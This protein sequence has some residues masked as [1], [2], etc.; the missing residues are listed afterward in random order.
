MYQFISAKKKTKLL[1]SFVLILSISVYI[2]TSC[3]NPLKATLNQVVEDYSTPRTVVYPL[4]G[5]GMDKSAS[6]IITFSML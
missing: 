3:E 2:F 5:E 6:V 4:N 1:Y